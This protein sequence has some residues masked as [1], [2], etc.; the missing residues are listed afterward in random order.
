[1]EC[2]L[3]ETPEEAGSR[4]KGVSLL[5]DV[6][7]GVARLSRFAVP[8]ESKRPTHNHDATKKRLNN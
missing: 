3:S 8:D 5:L 2:R 4:L 7:L 1:M 6:E